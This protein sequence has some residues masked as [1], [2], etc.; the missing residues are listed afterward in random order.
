MTGPL[1]YQCQHIGQN[2]I[3]TALGVVY[4]AKEQLDKPFLILTFVLHM[5]G[6]RHHTLSYSVV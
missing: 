1:V 5:L 4:F 6:G 2:I 3:G